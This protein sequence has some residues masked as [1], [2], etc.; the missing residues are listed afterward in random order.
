MSE[1][2]LE[3]AGHKVVE[4]LREQLAHLHEVIAQQQ[5][6]L[7]TQVVPTTTTNYVN[8]DV[9]P[10]DTAPGRCLDRTNYHDWVHQL[11]S[12]LVGC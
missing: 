4:N 6:T 12:S 10:Y 3:G 8:Y 11:R 5:A 1:S 9:I 7:S 2:L